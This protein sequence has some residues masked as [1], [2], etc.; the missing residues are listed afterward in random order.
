M[1]Q[2]ISDYLSQ[3]P[4]PSDQ[5]PGGGGLFGSAFS[6]AWN[7]PGNRNVGMGMMPDTGFYGHMT[8]KKADKPVTVIGNPSDRL[9]G[10]DKGFCRSSNLQTVN[11]AKGKAK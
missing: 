8:V 6:Q 4:D 3:H 10:Q 1:P 9:Q 2:L 7:Q 11:A 5:G